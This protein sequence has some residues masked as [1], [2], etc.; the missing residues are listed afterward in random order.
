[1][2]NSKP[3]EYQKICANSYRHRSGLY[4]TKELIQKIKDGF[5]VDILDQ[6][7]YNITQEFLM[8][9]VF[10]NHKGAWLYLYNKLG[11][12]DLTTMLEG[13]TNE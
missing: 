5:M 4:T 7:G 3:L 2:S 10:K 12:D 11:N 13:G 6:A 8:E 9:A 1:M